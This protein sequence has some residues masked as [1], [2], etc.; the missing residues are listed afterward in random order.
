MNDVSQRFAI[1]VMAG[2]R[3]ALNAAQGLARNNLHPR[4]IFILGEARSFANSPAGSTSSGPDAIGKLDGLKTGSSCIISL[5][6]DSATAP[7]V[8]APTSTVF[9]DALQQYLLPEH[10]RRLSGAIADGKF[11]VLAELHGVAEERSAT[12][13]LLQNSSSIVEVHDLQL[14]VTEHFVSLH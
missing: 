4:H 13:A 9:G 3:E 5:V 2:L 11:L 8:V 12:R 1:A 6:Y 7:S 10:A 14:A